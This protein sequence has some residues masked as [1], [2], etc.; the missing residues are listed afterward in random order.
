LIF[1]KEAKSYNG[2]KKASSSNGAGLN[3][4]LHLK[5]YK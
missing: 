2:K 5:A 1:K 4:C 3:G